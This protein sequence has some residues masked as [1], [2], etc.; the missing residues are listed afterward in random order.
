LTYQSLEQNVNSIS[1][2]IFFS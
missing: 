1:L 2:I